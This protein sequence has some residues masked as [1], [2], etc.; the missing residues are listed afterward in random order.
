MIVTATTVVLFVLGFLT[1]CLAIYGGRVAL[2][3]RSNLRG[4][5]DQWYVAEQ[6]YYLLA[7]IGLVVLIGRI[8]AVPLYFWMLQFLVPYCPGAMCAYG[9]VNVS[10][11]F[12]AIAV[13]LKVLLPAAYGFWIV[14]ELSNR[15]A[16][17]LPFMGWLASAFLVVLLPCV[18]IDSTM[19]VLTVAA[20]RP[21]L[22]PCCSS[23]YDVNPPFSPSAILGPEIG[24]IILACTVVLSLLLVPLQFVEQTT[25]I[26]RAT[27][28]ALAIIAGG[29]YLI[30]LHDTYAPLV[31]GLSSHHCPYCL[32]QEFPDTALFSALFWVGVV[33]VLWRVG[34][35]TLWIRHG[36]SLAPID[37]L[38]R[39]L[40]ELSAV[41]LLFSVVSVVSHVV[42]ALM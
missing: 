12:S 11:P 41:T 33:G 30:A 15:E 29:L 28:A 22:A 6:K 8:L 34:V 4:S 42:L 2:D 31:L 5:T 20:I 7:M 16:P 23:V 18:I 24:V 26:G 40:R 13:G 3:I 14:T 21:V 32:F 17:S 27:L 38:R 9:V 36:M 35:E 10:L 1:L 19:D 37:S 39:W 25:R